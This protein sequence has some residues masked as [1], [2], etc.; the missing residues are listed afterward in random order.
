MTPT[1]NNL[2]LTSLKL[3]GKDQVALAKNTVK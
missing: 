3:N 2:G 1:P